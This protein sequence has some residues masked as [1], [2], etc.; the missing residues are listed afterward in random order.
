MESE[1]GHKEIFI[2]TS[3]S[4]LILTEF[5]TLRYEAKVMFGRVQVYIYI[6]NI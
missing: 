3:S 5:T 2:A 6:V 1:Q 4:A